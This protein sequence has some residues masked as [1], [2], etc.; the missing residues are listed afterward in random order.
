MFLRSI[1]IIPFLFFLLLTGATGHAADYKLKPGAGGKLCLNCHTTFTE[2]L[3]KRFQHTPVKAGECASCHN[4]HAADHGKLL[5]AAP[6]EIC[7]GCHPTVLPE[8]ARSVHQVVAQGKCISCHDPHAAEQKNNL[9]KSGN[10]L[11]FG[12]HT[13]M[14]KS[15]AGLK[16][17]HAPVSKNCLACHAP[18][19]STGGRALLTADPPALCQ[20]CHATGDKKFAAVHMNYPVEKADCTACH[21]PH[22]SSQKAILYDAVHAP[23]AKRMC[24]QCHAAATSPTPLQ[25][26][27]NGFE[28]CRG[29]HSEMVNTA[30]GKEHLHWP[31]AGGNGCLECHSPHAAKKKNLL[32]GSLLTVCGRCHEDTMKRQERSPTKH[33]PIQDGECASCH[34]PHASD[35]SFLLAKASVVE[36]CATCHEWQKHSTHPIGSNF[37]DPRNANMTLDCLSCHR[38]HGT[39][40]KHLIPFATTTN[41]CVQCHDQYKR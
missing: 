34:N 15:L 8:K 36:Q 22:G 32:A 13:A 6:G 33:Q 41:L 4:P 18:H 30:F 26:K 29:C 10:E 39:E 27:K 7:A 35:N 9:L 31:L 24:N 3:K 38:S 25:V 20:K 14:Q 19:A 37:K 17:P 1:T 28:L 16:V 11:C 2:I 40:Y 23:V 12:C 5:E 21:D